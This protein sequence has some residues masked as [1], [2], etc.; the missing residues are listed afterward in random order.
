MDWKKIAFLTLGLLIIA[1]LIEWAGVEEVLDVL[2]KARLDYFLLAVLAYIAGVF[3][4]ALRWRVLLK[5]LGINAPFKAIL[6]AIFVGIFVNNVTPGARGGGEPIR[7]YYLSKRSNGA[8]GPVFATVM[9]DRI[10]DLIPVVIMLMTSTI[11]VYLLGSRSLTIMLLIL[12]F[13]LALLI[14]IT[15]AILLNERRTKKILYWF[16][17]LVSRIMPKRAQKYD[18]KFIHNIE[19]SVPKFQEGF[20]LLLKDKKTFFLALAYSFV[21]WFLTILR[22]YFIFLSIN[23]PIGLMDVMVVQMISIVVG[24]LSII[25]GGAGFIEAINSGVYVLLG[26][27]KNFAVTATLIERVVSYWAPTIFGGFITTHFGIKVSEEKKKKSLTD[28][29]EKK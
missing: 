12:D 16:F 7:M 26:I 8:Y 11:Y 25:P 21:F 24:L 1:L 13:L 20:R 27:D 9:A 18:E 3:I 17:N 15:L 4:W 10:L 29:G 14:V 2:K 6:G 5:S 22:A 28:E 23:Y 19:V